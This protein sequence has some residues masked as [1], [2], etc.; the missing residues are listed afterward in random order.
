MTEALIPRPDVRVAPIAKSFDEMLKVAETLLK[1]GFLPQSIKT[2]A[3]AVSIILMGREVGLPEMQ[4]LR[5]INVIQGKPTLSAELMLALF[6]SRVNGK[7]NVITSNDQEC[8]IKFERPGRE[9]HIQKFTIEQAKRLNLAGKDNYA[10]QPATMLQWRCVSAG[11]RFYAPDAIAGISYTP[12]EL[13]AAVNYETGEVIDLS[14]AKEEDKLGD[15]FGVDDVPAVDLH[16]DTGFEIGES[17]DTPIGGGGGGGA[18]FEPPKPPK[19][20]I[21]PENQKF[22]TEMKKQKLRIGAKAYYEVM[23]GA[24]FSHSWEV[25]DRKVQTAIWN[26]MKAIP[27]G[28]LV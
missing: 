9:P 13:G 22:C 19:P 1:S 17:K 26:T 6:S 12:D 18:I 8:V 25:L 23:G 15:A 10:K 2:P 11:L 14:L 20:K 27:D 16:D 7:A 3:Q 28:G 21:T 5:S 24:G 4:A